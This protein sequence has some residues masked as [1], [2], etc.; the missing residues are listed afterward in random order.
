M[1][2]EI[3]TIIFSESLITGR[4]PAMAIIT[5]TK[6][7][8]VTVGFPYH[9]EGEN[10]ARIAAYALCEKFRWTPHNLAGGQLKNGDY[11][12]VFVDVVE[13]SA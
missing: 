5:N 8:S 7:G 2:L 9:T 3:K 11:V 1:S 12:F 4:V 13:K 10:A 6:A